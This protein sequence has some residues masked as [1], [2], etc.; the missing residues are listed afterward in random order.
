MRYEKTVRMLVP[1]KWMALEY[2]KDDYLTMR[3]DVW[4]FGVL[5]WEIF[6]FGKSPYGRISYDELLPRLENGYRLSCPSEIVSIT[7]WSPA[8]LY[9]FLAAVCFK[10]DPELRASFVEVVE[11]IE[12]EL[13]EEERNQ[14]AKL[15][16]IYNI[17]TVKMISKLAKDNFY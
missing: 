1:W 3:S 4:S 11:I 2:L 8:E 16:E 15:S 5:L 10:E 9:F 6:S 14:Y 17:A 12:K 13:N 7:S